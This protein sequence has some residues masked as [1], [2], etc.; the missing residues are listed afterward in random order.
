M[1]K[2]TLDKKK[3]K[4]MEDY[5]NATNASTGSKYDANA[6]ITVKNIATLSYELPKKDN[7]D[8][9]RAVMHKYLTKLYNENIA[10][11]YEID[12]N[13]HIIYAHDESGGSGGFPYC[14]SISLYP[15]FNEWTKRF[16]R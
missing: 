11:Q 2:S 13:N 3:L 8:L 4:F 9:Q 5:V 10:N 6:N 16:R 12:L 7:I 15:F 14:C 1:R